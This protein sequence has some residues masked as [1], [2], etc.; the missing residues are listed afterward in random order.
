LLLGVLLFNK[1]P[2]VLYDST[3]TWM[4]NQFIDLISKKNLD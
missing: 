4:L 1:K 3:K 2:R